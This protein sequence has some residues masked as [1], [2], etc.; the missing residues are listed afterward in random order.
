MI[1]AEID[2]AVAALHAGKLVI[3]P[4]DTVYGLA[5]APDEEPV[6]L[7]YRTKGRGEGQPT[8][9][10]AATVEQLL[11]RIPE[12]RGRAETIARALLPGLYTLVLPNPA[13]RYPWLN[14]G[15]PATIGVRVPALSG[16]GRQVLD[17]VGPLAA[18]SA[19]LAGGSDPRTL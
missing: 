2:A 14:G 5:A 16:P 18:T 1:E 4:T 8:A 6:R 11:E 3:L 9:L 15:S 7:L 17:R 13:R 10:V 19:N 12:L